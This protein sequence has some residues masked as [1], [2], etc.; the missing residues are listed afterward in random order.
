MNE[1]YGNIDWGENFF[2]TNFVFLN[3]K[4]NLLYVSEKWA[5]GA[6]LENQFC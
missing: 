4:T 3:Q 2:K 6:S 1:C 5:C